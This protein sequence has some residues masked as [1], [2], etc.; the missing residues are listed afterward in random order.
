MN[1]T[2]KILAILACT[3][4]AVGCGTSGSGGGGGGGGGNVGQD[5]NTGGGSDAADTTGGDNDTG[6]STDSDT[7]GGT[8]AGDKC[9]CDGKECGFIPGCL[10][11]CGF[12][13]DGKACNTAN[14]C[15]AK[16]TIQLKKFGEWCGPNKDCQPPPAGTPS[17]STAAAAYRD[18]LNAQCETNLCNN[19][20]CSKLCAIAADKKNNVSG[21]DGA[22]GIEDEGA[23]SECADAVD[24]PHGD[25]FACVELRTEAEVAQAG[26]LALC[27]P[28]T[29]WKDCKVD[30]DCG[31]TET[32]RLYTIYGELT[33]RCGPKG[34]NP[35][36]K[37]GAKVTQTCNNNVVEG[38]VAICENNF[39]T[40]LGCTSFCNEDTD[41]ISAP[42]ACKDSKCPN[43]KAC[44]G[45]ADCSAWKC[46]KGVSLASDDPTKFNICWPKNCELDKD[47][48]DD[49]AY[50]RISYNGVQS[51]EGEPDPDDAT[52]T[53]LPGWSNICMSNPPN[54]AKKGEKCD[55]IGGDEDTSLPACGIFLCDGGYCG[56]LCKGDADCPT[57]MTCGINEIPFDLDDP[58]DG[59]N[60][61]FLPIGRCTPTPGKDGTCSSKGDCKEG[62]YCKLYESE[63]NLPAGATPTDYKYTLNGACITP[64]ADKKNIGDQCGSATTETGLGKLCQSGVCLNTTNSAGQ[65]QPGYCS[66]FCGAGKS[67]CPATITAYGQQYK[68]ICRS[69]L[70]AWNGTKDPTDDIYVPLCLPTVTTNSLTDCGTSKACTGANEACLGFPV[71]SGPDKVAKVEYSCMSVANAPTQ[72]DPNPP[73]PNKNVGEECDLESD[74]T[75]CKTAYCLESDVTGKGYCSRVCNEDTD[76]GTGMVCDKGHMMIQ[77]K[78]P[79]KAAYMPI[80]KKIKSC[81]PCL[82][83][84]QCG[85]GNKCTNIGSSGTLANMR[86]APPCTSDSDC[87][88]TDGG[89]KCVAA[90]DQ[91]GK[92]LGHKV[93]APTCK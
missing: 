17:N 13:T 90:K 33:S 79:S 83:D 16:T 48:G 14:K 63:I 28:Y 34:K 68:T 52:K 76:C 19:N 50:C 9:S 36:G 53:I 38:P 2:S 51:P 70:W 87:A 91:D 77:R 44:T 55:P 41:C 78:D 32:C 31:A 11:S 8:D 24:G 35:D 49:N 72:A 12:C 85:G 84:Y 58:D 42:G 81:I 18:C 82:Y 67:D 71:A 39:C 45:D 21:A 43:G 92:E 56:A 65:A 6:G 64:D 25:K 26:S 7:A 89:S 60:D 47:C 86:C 61:V 54:G 10:K 59:I 80:C 62:K 1:R 75:Q 27:T 30:A 46:D 40:G 29:T 4:F 23:N 93:C 66:D 3:V 20:H 15:E 88:S 57:N 22:D 69:L 5:T 74:Y 37:P 73:Q